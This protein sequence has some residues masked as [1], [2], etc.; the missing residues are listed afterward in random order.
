MKKTFYSN[1]KL[2]LTGEYVVLDGAKAIALPTKYGQFLDIEKG[3]EQMIRWQSY[4]AD[5]S[6]WFEDHISFDNIRNKENFGPQAGIKNT[7]IEILYEAAQLN[8]DFLTSDTGYNVTTRLTFPRL[9]GLGTSSTLINNIAQWLQVDA[10][11]LLESSFGGSGYDIACAQNN[12]PII[13]QLTR[14][15][16]PMVT[17]LQLHLSFCQNL[18]FVYLNQKQSSK[19]AIMSYYDKQQRI[20]KMIPKIDALTEAILVTDDL[21]QFGSLINQHESILSDILEMETVKE[22]FFNDFKGVLKSLGAWGGDF[23]LAIAP[24]DPTAYFKEKGFPIVIPYSE[25]IL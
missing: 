17:P 19:S 11:R 14:F 1:G 18:Y 21:Y 24:N 2:L 7:L 8:P 10:Y 4:D 20:D 13:Y 16:R 3:P 23:I 9:W 25:M 22:R 6:I 5:S 15:K 12:T